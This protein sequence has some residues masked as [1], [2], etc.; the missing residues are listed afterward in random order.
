MPTKKAPTWKAESLVQRLAHC[1]AMLSIHGMLSDTERHKALNR[2]RKAF[3]TRVA[4][5]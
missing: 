4:P 1:V 3:S 2:I 5:S